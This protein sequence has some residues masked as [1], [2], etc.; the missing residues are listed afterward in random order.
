MKIGPEGNAE[1][2]VLGDSGRIDMRGCSGW[3]LFD[4]EFAPLAEGKG[5]ATGLQSAAAA[6][7]LLRGAPGADIAVSHAPG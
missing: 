4:R 6:F 3:Q 7:L 1:W 5:G 2:R